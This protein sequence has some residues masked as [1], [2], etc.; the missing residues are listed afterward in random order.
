MTQPNIVV[1]IHSTPRVTTTTE[2]IPYL[3]NNT[4]HK[5]RFLPCGVTGILYNLYILVLRGCAGLV[6][7]TLSRLLADT[8]SKRPPPR[9]PRFLRPTFAPAAPGPG[10]QQ[11]ASDSPSQQAK[12]EWAELLAGEAAN[13]RPI[14]R[15]KKECYGLTVWLWGYSRGT[16]VCE[17]AMACMEGE[18]VWLGEND[19]AWGLKRG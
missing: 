3:S 9:P 7:I 4:P 1:C 13:T 19:W 15:P 11:L 17:G 14:G 18:A 6:K 12:A 5:Y 2:Q 16:A 10:P 8:N